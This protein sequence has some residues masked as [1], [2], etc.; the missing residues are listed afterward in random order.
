MAPLKA[1][2]LMDIA[3]A[4]KAQR[5]ARGGQLSFSAWEADERVSAGE[6]QL[7]RNA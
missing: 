3:F 4:F 1:A 6:W 2:L 5:A 7:P